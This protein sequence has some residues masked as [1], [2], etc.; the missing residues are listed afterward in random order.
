MKK[1]LFKNKNKNHT[2][3][4]GKKY[5]SIQYFFWLLSG[6]EINIL[7]DCPTDYNRQAGIGFTIFMTTVLA[8]C[9]G[10]YAGW[11]FGESMTTAIVFGLLWSA[12]IFSID[13]SMVVTL[14]KDPTKKEQ[15]FWVPLLSR[16]IMALL[17]AFI[18]SIPLELL[19]FQENIELH[20]PKYKL[21]QINEIKQASERNQNIKIKTENF[22]R[23]KDLKSKVE[24]ELAYGEP[25]GDPIYDNLKTEYN[26]KNSNFKSLKDLYNKARRESDVA[27]NKVPYSFDN[28]SNKNE[29]DKTSK[30]W[31]I[32]QKRK[33][34]EKEARK[35]LNNFNTIALNKARS[36]KDNYLRNWISEKD[37]EKNILTKQVAKSN[38]EIN[39]STTV[40]DRTAKEFD[41]LIQNKKGF[42]LRFMI[43][44]DLATRYR[45]KRK[46]VEDN[47]I[48]KTIAIAA[49]TVAEAVDKSI[50]VTDAN[51]AQSKLD[52]NTTRKTKWIEDEEY[53]PEGATIFFLLWLIRI[54]FFT[55]EILPTIA[56]I[57][58][59]LGAYDIA[60]YRKEREI[61]ED[62]EKR[63]EDYI[64][65]QK[66]IRELENLA[67]QEQ[68]ISK[69]KIENELHQD[70]LKEIASAQNDVAKK[71]IEDFRKKHLS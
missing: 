13:R 70:I 62:L 12:L 56:K 31:E 7:K 10:S 64:K 36:D 45:K 40:I 1:D 9:S 71:Q 39:I 50:V 66:E 3:A 48:N 65:H 57:A 14:K 17:I 29:K 47:E 2:T 68:I 30:S 51:N 63:T 44:E 11:Y 25:Q 67:H 55:I 22:N 42:V 38:K 5:T 23:N 4:K 32:Y 46:Q 16:G 26:I 20:M 28:I 61:Q 52:E 35:N 60:I 8:F 33:A 34:E 49:D 27:Y 6:C 54:L 18:I 15:S 69:N 21:D 53:N 37:K 58:T 19:I 24:N 43:L 59:P 41:S